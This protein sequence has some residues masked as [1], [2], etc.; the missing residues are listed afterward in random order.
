MMRL[1]YTEHRESQTPRSGAM[2]Q[3]REF[4]KEKFKPSKSQT[5]RSGAMFQT[6]ICKEWKS[7]EQLGLKPLEAGQCFRLYP[8]NQPFY[9]EVARQNPRTSRFFASGTLLGIVKK[10]LVTDNQ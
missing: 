9:Q 5:P 10:V 8:Q 7:I 4:L 6:C 1:S 2:F 3:T